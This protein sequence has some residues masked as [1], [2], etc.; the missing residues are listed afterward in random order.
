VGLANFRTPAADF[1]VVYIDDMTGGLVW[2]QIVCNIS[3]ETPFTRSRSWL[4]PDSG[5]CFWRQNF[6]AET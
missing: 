3:P 1:S 6:Y 2:G 5:A 4:V